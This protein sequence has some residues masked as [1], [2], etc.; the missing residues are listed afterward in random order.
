MITT[1][2][3]L[4]LPKAVAEGTGTGPDRRADIDAKQERVAGLLREIGCDGLLVLDPDNFGWLTSGALARG[5]VNPAELPALFFTGEGRWLIAGNADSQRLFDEEMDGLGFQLKEWPWHWGRDQLLADICQ[6]RT[7]A[8]DLPLGSCRPIADRLRQMRRTLSQYERACYRSLG[9]IARHALEATCRTLSAGETEREIAGQLSH[10]LFH[11]GVLPVAIGVAADGRSRRYRHFGFTSTPLRHYGVLW[12]AARKYGLT[13][14]ASRSVSFGAP[15]DS[16]RQD[17]NVACK[18]SATYLASCW[19]DAVPREI[20]TTGKRVYLLT[21]AEHEWQRC[22]QGY[23]TGRTPVEMA[24]TPRTE[25]LFQPHWAITWCPTVGAA[26]SCDTFLVTEQG[27]ETIT[28]PDNW[29][30]KRIR[31]QGVDFHRPD[32]LQR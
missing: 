7:V 27:P 30:L 3:T 28:V 21:G 6:G 17:H 23:V 25:D 11:R 13:V 14:T 19:P 10:R 26:S 24:L 8:S 32:I 20:L 2:E 18:V 1:A 22:P 16:F 4:P 9:I 5:V 29:P 12:V 31:V 15:E